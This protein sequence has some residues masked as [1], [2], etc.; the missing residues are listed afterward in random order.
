MGENGASFLARLADEGVEFITSTDTWFRPTNFVNGPDGCLYVLDMYR[1]TIEHPIAIPDDIKA[2]LNLESGDDKGRIYRLVPPGWKQKPF[3]VL[4]T[5]TTTELVASLNSTNGW[6]RETAQRLLWE[7]QDKAAIEPCSQ[8]G[9][10]RGDSAGAAARAG[11]PRRSE[12][13]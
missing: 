5:K 11:G 6:E 8:A 9:P 1:E 4:A 7:R 12:C 10:R 2:F 3:P 13:D